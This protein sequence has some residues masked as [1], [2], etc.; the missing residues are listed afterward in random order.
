[1]DECGTRSR[2]YRHLS[3]SETLFGWVVLV[4]AFAIG[5][6][7]L[8]GYA[9]SILPPCFRR[10]P[11]WGSSSAGASIIIGSSVSQNATLV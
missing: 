8:Y 2:H 7:N 6:L 3:L 1:M 5:G 4:F 11:L 10:S 9:V